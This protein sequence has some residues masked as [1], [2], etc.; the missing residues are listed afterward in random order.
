LTDGKKDGHG[1]AENGAVYVFSRKVKKGGTNTITSNI[2]KLERTFQGFLVKKK[3]QEH[4]K[5]SWVVLRCT[6]KRVSQK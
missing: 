5:G 4:P 6:L 3:E 1:K 2:T